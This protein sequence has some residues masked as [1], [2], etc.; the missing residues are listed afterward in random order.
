MITDKELVQAAKGVL[1]NSYSPYSKFKVGAALLAENGKIYT[2]VNIE[3][4]TF[5]A[6]ICAE[7]VA[8]YNAVSS[9]D[10][11]FSK[12]AIVSDS[13]EL[14]YPCGI[15][16]QVMSEFCNEDF[17]IILCSKNEL[18]IY[19]LTELLPHSFML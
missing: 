15:C 18:E 16:R 12:I 13:D 17:E 7:R 9:G 3:N 2:G 5:G 4:A 1:K 14:C 8:I 19:K 11:V 6:T 10:I